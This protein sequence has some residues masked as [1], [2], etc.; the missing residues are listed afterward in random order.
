MANRM[1]RKLK[2]RIKL[3]KEFVWSKFSINHPDGAQIEVL[4]KGLKYL[5]NGKK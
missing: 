5:D 2:K 4:S 1:P 3:M